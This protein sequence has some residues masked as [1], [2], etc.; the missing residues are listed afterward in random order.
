MAKAKT[1]KKAGTAS[2]TKVT[3]KKTGKVAGEPREYSMN[4]QFSKGDTVY[5]KIW[6]DT[7]EV[8]EVGTTD[9]G[10][11]KIKVSFEKVGIK[12]LRSS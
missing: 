6:D 12:S 2:E 5:H 11:S 3:R 10:I 9:D 1:I 4:E 7:G 8:L